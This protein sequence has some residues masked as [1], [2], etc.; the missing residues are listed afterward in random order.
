VI[1]I[2]DVLSKA[3]IK[4][5]EKK[6]SA[7]YVFVGCI[8]DD[9]GRWINDPV[10]IFYTEKAHKN[11]SNYF[12]VYPYKDTYYVC[13]GISA[14]EGKL[15]GIRAA[16][17]DIIYSSFRHDYVKSPDNSVSIDGGRD[18]IRSTGYSLV[19]LEVVK[20]KL[21]VHDEGD[22]NEQKL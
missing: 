10:S 19:V 21:V 15:T 18:Y 17:G 11:G 12:G 2:N 8:K 22:S 6:Y 3:V 9:N 5:I 20:D 7:K 14:V 13:D 4:E 1:I 16:N